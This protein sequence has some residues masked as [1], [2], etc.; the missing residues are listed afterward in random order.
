MKKKLNRRL[1]E[2]VESERLSGGAALLVE[3]GG[4]VGG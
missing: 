2:L 1:G 4:E 3:L